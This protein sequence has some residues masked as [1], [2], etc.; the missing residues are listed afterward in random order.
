M[1]QGAGGAVSASPTTLMHILLK[2]GPL[3]FHPTC[4]KAQ[5][6]GL[7]DCGLWVQPHHHFLEVRSL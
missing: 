2:A 4:A 1:G 7:S 6:M 5:A 3:G